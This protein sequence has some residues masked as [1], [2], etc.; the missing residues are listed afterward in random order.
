MRF[1]PEQLIDELYGPPKKEGQKR[2]EDFKKK[3]IPKPERPKT[4]EILEAAERKAREMSEKLNQRAQEFK[5]N[6][7]YKIETPQNIPAWLT[8]EHLESLN[9]IFGQNNLELYP[10]PSPETLDN[11]YLTIMYPESQR[12]EDQ[13]KGLISYRPPLWNNQS[14][15]TVTKSKETWG[16]AYARSMRAELEK[17]QNSLILIESIQKPNYIDGS[18]HYGEKEGTNS[19]L[20]LLLPA[21]QE[22]FGQDQNRF[23][24]S[25]DELSQNLLPKVKEK[26]LKIFQ[27]KNLPFS[28]NDFEVIL[29]PAPLFNLQTTFYH[30]ENSQ[31]NTWEWTA[32]PLEDAKG[33]DS[34]HRLVVGSSD[35]GGVAYV[36][37]DHRGNH[38]D[39]RGARLAVVF[40]QS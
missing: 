17:L 23:N 20:D 38:W 15:Q 39:D 33:R 13:T 5:L 36:A 34:G 30:P 40:S 31:T 19:K 26:I 28:E 3:N 6:K 32:T 25:H 9:E 1:R 12:K 7:D 24:H 37:N 27:E 14:D 35:L 10:I 21:F 22:T 2:L 29:T 4:A 16:Q 11:D 8:P 18:Q